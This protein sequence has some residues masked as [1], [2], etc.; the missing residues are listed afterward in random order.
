MAKQIVKYLLEADGTVPKFIT[1]GGFFPV[2]EEMIGVTIDESKRHL[3]KEL[4]RITKKELL[5]HIKLSQP[6][7]VDSVALMQ[8]FLD[9]VKMKDIADE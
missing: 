5:A 8:A 7:T 3:P 1:D 4:K 9:Q 2:N 6:E